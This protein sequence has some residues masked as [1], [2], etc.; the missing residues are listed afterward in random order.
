M[1]SMPWL[2][3][4]V[5]VGAVALAAAL[6]ALVGAL[7]PPPTADAAFLTVVAP[8]TMVAGEAVVVLA[9][10]S[11]PDGPTRYRLRVCG[12]VCWT[13]RRGELTGPDAWWGRL[14]LLELERG[15]YRLTLDL[16]RPWGHWGD[17]TVASHAWEVEAH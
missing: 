13:A 12:D 1:T 10:I 16:L 2:V 5:L 14:A 11:L 4:A 9:G 3:G 15:R 7:P 8:R 17:R 6:P